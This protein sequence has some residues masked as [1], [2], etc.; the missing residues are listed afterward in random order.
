MTILRTNILG[1]PNVGIFS[2][3]TDK[4]TIVPTGLTTRKLTRIS[5]ALNTEIL[6]VDIGYSKLIG[7]LAVANSNGIALPH[8]AAE[9][10]VR[11]I[12][13]ILKIKVKRVNSYKTSIG[14]L[15][16]ANDNG[17]LLSPLFTPNEVKLIKNI[18]N[19]DVKL[20]CIAKCPL[21]GSVAVATNKGAIVHPKT[22][23]EE[24]ELVAEILKVPVTVG[25]VNNGVPF[26]SSGLTINSYGAVAGTLTTGPELMVIS[27]LM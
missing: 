20:G 15:V 9:S 17:A 26:V 2:L 23:E 16:L 1:S 10:E 3:S 22:T 13:K 8:Y 4:F 27:S 11:T 7:V 24:K 25:T 5:D 21:V 6:S 19:T 14:N 18:L 12:K